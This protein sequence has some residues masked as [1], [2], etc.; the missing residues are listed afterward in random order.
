MTTMSIFFW[1][2]GVLWQKPHQTRDEAFRSYPILF[3]CSELCVWDMGTLML[4]QN[5]WALLRIF[6]KR[7]EQKII[8][9]TSDVFSPN[10]RRDSWNQS[11]YAFKQCCWLF[12]SAADVL[13][14]NIKPHSSKF[15]AYQE[16][17]RDIR[18]RLDVFAKFTQAGDHV[19]LCHIFH[20]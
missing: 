3:G 2:I 15:E 18:R 9:S 11:L 10:S 12:L 13:D 7:P 19:L 6:E 5:G 16:Q 14:G 20:V 8:S 1:S 17:K 4:W